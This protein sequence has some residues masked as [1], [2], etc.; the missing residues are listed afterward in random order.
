[1]SYNMQTACETARPRHYIS[2]GWRHMAPSAA[3][4]ANLS[5]IARLISQHDV[6]GLQEV[7]AG[8][9]RTRRYNQ[10]ERLAK[11]AGFGYWHTRVN[12]DFGRFAQHGLGL[13]S[14]VAPTHVSEHSLPGRIPGRG[15]LIAH[16]EGDRSRLA[17]AVAHLALGTRTQYQQLAALCDL[18][19]DAEHAIILADTNCSGRALANNP[20][21]ARLQMRTNAPSLA[22]YPSW[23][24]RRDLDHIICSSGLETQPSRVINARLSDHRPVSQLVGCPADVFAEPA[25]EDRSTSS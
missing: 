17:V 19:A 13:V 9:W 4:H 16:F 11:L 25:P 2:R 21:L 8:S 5:R 10:V 14:R 22:S 15:A 12:R 1:M 20:S 24:P 23:H 6:V 3:S 18:L 7:D